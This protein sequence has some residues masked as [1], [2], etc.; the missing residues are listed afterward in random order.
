MRTYFYRKGVYFFDCLPFTTG[1]NDGIK[2][3]MVPDWER[4]SDIKVWEA[5]AVQVHINANLNI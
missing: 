2:F 4:L 5:A 3:Y 1:A